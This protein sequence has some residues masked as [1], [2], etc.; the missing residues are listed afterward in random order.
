MYVC[1]SLTCLLREKCMQHFS[2]SV[3]CACSRMLSVQSI[4]HNMQ[5]QTIEAKDILLTEFIKQ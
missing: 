3:D 5:V 2:L 1:K 4:C